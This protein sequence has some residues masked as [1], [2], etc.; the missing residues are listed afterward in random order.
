VVFPGVDGT[1]GVVVVVV[2][3]EGVVVEGIVV[4]GGSGDGWA[5]AG[6]AVCT[7]AGLEICV[8]RGC[9]FTGV[10]DRATASCWRAAP[11][12]CPPATRCGTA[13]GCACVVATTTCAPL[14]AG[15]ASSRPTAS[16]APT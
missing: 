8:A 3:V 5:G 15:I 12:T 14:G 2:G 6:V 16:S 4:V 1:A 13:T 11:G 10:R 7:E 9:T